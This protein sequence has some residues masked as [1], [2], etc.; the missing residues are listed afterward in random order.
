VLIIAPK[1]G[2]SMLSAIIRKVFVVIV[3]HIATFSSLFWVAMGGDMIG[4]QWPCEVPAFYEPIRGIPVSPVLL[5]HHQSANM[6]FLIIFETE[7]SYQHMIKPGPTQIHQHC[8]Q[9]WSTGS[10]FSTQSALLQHISDSQLFKLLYQI[11]LAHVVNP[12]IACL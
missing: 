3:K 11:L 9:A 12:D 4:M 2:V 5:L 1:K 10:A 7:A 6:I 8:W